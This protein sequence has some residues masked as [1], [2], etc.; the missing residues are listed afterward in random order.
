[1]AFT[2]SNSHILWQGMSFP[3]Y[4]FIVSCLIYLFGR[5]LIN[6]LGALISADGHKVAHPASGLDQAE[7]G[8]LKR[9]E[10]M[11]DDEIFQLEKRA[12]FSKTWLYI[13]HRSRFDK[14]GDYHVFDVAGISFFVVLGKDMK[15]R[16][17]HNVCRHRAYTVVRKSCG[18]S[19][20]F[21]CKYHGWQYDD[22]GKL[23]KAPKFDESLGFKPEENGLWEVKLILTREGLVFVNFD[24]STMHLPFNNVRSHVDMGACS[25]VDGMDLTCETNWKGLANEFSNQSQWSQNPFG[26]FSGFRR[27]KMARL[28]GPMSMIK[29]LNEDLWCTMTLLPRSQ[30]EVIVRCDIYAKEGTNPSPQTFQRWKWLLEKELNV[31]SKPD[32]AKA[33]GRSYFAYQCGGRTIDLFAIL[34]QHQRNEKMAKKKLQPA[35]RVTG[36]AD[37]DEEATALCD[38][39]DG[40]G[41]SPPLENCSRKSSFPQTLEW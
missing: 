15:L 40:K 11:S 2:V 18:T 13:S 17:F 34:A 6:C 35:I 7:K 23:V 24:A 20:R 4:L 33:S 14:A 12:F 26:W 39:L 5:S 30:S 9:P 1:M 16:A 8:S 36:L 38:V 3:A 41:E 19:A 29:E 25:W 32:E 27:P 10:D 37:I 31:L 21:S 22:E 28:L